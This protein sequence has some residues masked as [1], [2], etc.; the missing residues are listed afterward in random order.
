MSCSPQAAEREVYENALAA[1]KAAAGRFV[2][3]DFGPRNVERL[4]SFLE[5]AQETG[6]R[7][8]LT[9][10]DVLLLEAMHLVDSSVPDPAED[11][12]VVLYEKPKAR[13]D[14]WERHVYEYMTGKIV[15]PEEISGNP[16]DYILCFSFYDLNHLVDINPPTGG[17][18]IYSSSEL[19][20][21]E[22][23]FDFCRLRNWVRRFG[24][25][26][27]GDPED[28]ESEVRYHASGHIT[29]PELEE[30][31]RTIDPKYVIPVHTLTPQWF[32]DRFS[33]EIKAVTPERCVP[34]SIG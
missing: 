21:E 24:M 8:A 32:V 12:R 25:T 10:K 29:G 11:S 18:Y 5:I 27:V 2:I 31:M 19:Y 20:G 3:A 33:R 17:I 15:E 26:M 23:E 9:A 13:I 16:G 4:V 22:Q 1:V 28:K 6:R 30:L 7:L 14:G 34:I